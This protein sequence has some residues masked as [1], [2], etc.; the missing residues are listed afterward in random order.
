MDATST[1][2]AVRALDSGLIPS[3]ILGG[4]SDAQNGVSVKY[5]PEVRV[6]DRRKWYVFRASYGRAEKASGLIEAL[7][8]RTYVARHTVHKRIDGHIRQLKEP[9]IPG[10]L[11]AFITEEQSRLLTKGVDA[12]GRG[13]MFNALSN[14]DKATVAQLP[15]II[16]YYYNHFETRKDGTNPPLTIPHDVMNKFIKATEP[17]GDVQPVDEHLFKIGEEVEVAEG[18]FKGLCGKVLRKPDKKNR[19]YVQ[20]HEKKVPM[21]NKKRR[22]LIKLPCLGSFCSALIPVAYFRKIE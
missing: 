11:F 4:C 3:T 15:K 1:N 9:L 20:L 13:T 7:G 2:Y 6:D 8:L 16:S 5:V 21:I 17:E 18:E 10:I 12:D 19:I 14:D 22:L